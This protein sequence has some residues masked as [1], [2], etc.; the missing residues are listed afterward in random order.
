[1]TDLIA[2][3]VAHGLSL[4]AAQLA[5]GGLLY[6]APL[7]AIVLPIAGL[8]QIF[9]RKIAAAMQRRVGP[10]TT[11]IDGVVRFILGLTMPWLDRAGRVR[12]ADKLLALP[13]LAFV[14]RLA[15]RS[16]VAQLIADSLKMIGKEDLLPAGV[17]GL[18]VRAAPY[19]ALL[20]AFLPFVVL[21]WSQHVQMADLSIGV[22]WILACGGLVVAAIVAAG[23]G[24]NNKWSLLG[25][26]R[27]V[28]QIVSYEIPVGLCIAAVVMW[29]GTMSLQQMIAAQY[30]PGIA[31]FAGWNL[32][33]SPFMVLLAV[34]FFIGALAECQR[35]PFDTAEAESELVSGFNTELSGL[36]WGLFA[37]A[38][39]TDMFLVCALFAVLFLGGYQSPIGEQW[40]LSLPV[41][42]ESLIHITI[43]IAKTMIGVWIM[44][45]IRWTLP[46]FRIDQVMRLAW[47]KLVPLALIGMFGL[48]VTMLCS[49][50]DV[51]VY[52]VH[53][54]A[55]SAQPGLALWALSWIVVGG[56]TWILVQAARSAGP[57]PHP[58][59]AKLT[60]LERRT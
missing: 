8:G 59:L 47:L 39:Y 4:T 11:G 16:G 26:M 53:A 14:N 24:S 57:A 42:A 28:A 20:G 18:I 3:F 1:M 56:G 50:T 55:I 35:T 17:D 38:E 33:Q 34:V 27:A 31:S 15:T 6:A 25:G 52:G 36:R 44:M 23:W 13:P 2:W 9:E 58:S 7:L 10:S 54:S 21:P 32:V 48:A 19:L 46:R 30:Q 43:L 51:V 37:M 60:S 45:W 12:V 41:L 22:L 40:I 5:A 29:T 49:R